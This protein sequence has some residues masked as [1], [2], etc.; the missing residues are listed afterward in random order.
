M[1]T[2]QK[3]LLLRVALFL[4]VSLALGIAIAY[5]FFMQRVVITPPTTPPTTTTPGTLPIAPGFTGGG[6]VAPSTTQPGLTPSPIAD[7]GPTLTTQLTASAI[8]APVLTNGQQISYYDPADGRFYTI[9][10]DGNITP[11]SEARFPAAENVT[12]APSGSI[13]ALTF[14]DGRNIVYDLDSGKQTTMPSHWDEFAFT[15]SGAQ[16]ASKS[17]A[18]DSGS[19]LVVTNSDG[20]QASAIAN[21]GA[22]A[23]EV[24]INWSPAGNVVAFSETGSAQSAFGR[25]EIYVID[26][27]GKAIGTLVVEGSNFSAKWAPN[28]THILYS[29]AQTSRNDRPSLWFV[30]AA[31]NNIGSGRKNLNLETWVEKCAFQDD[32]FVICAVPKQVTDFSGFD[33]RLITGGD[34]IYQVNTATGRST[35][36]AEPA[37]DMQMSNLHVSSDASLLYFTDAS[38]RLNSMRLR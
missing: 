9:D 37:I 15:E 28:G 3:T 14:P 23:N 17:I 36:L 31:G 8:S 7:G 4:S 33:H 13:A 29:V 6:T 25:Q 22:N 27:S 10:R 30:E 21:L 26:T 35:L 18:Q 34:N 32:T 5:F 24:K 11:I 12:F 19:S 1:M 16:L 2:A 20:S 38:G